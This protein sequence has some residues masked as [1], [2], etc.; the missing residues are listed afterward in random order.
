MTAVVDEMLANRK[1]GLVLKFGGKDMWNFYEW[2]RYSD[3]TLWSAEAVRSDLAINCLTV[4]AIDCIEHLSASVGTSFPYQGIANDLRYH[5]RKAFFVD[6]AFVMHENTSEYTS[7]GNSLAILAKVTDG[8]E[9]KAICK[10]IVKG[11]FVETSISMKLLSYTALLS[12][13]PT[14]EAFILD[15]IR[16]TYSYM[17]SSGHDTVWETV[18]GWQDFHD[19]GSLCHG[20]SAIPIYFFHKFGI[21]KK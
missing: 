15:E 12:V 4:M 13:D 21:A 20:W 2:T 11:E 10:R 6:G 14:Y 16:R 19:A 18:G 3:G 5:I 7:L 17:L 9:A 1:D 8:D